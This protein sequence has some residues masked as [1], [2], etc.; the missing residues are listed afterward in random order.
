MRCVE[1]IE[2]KRLRIEVDRL[3]SKIAKLEIATEKVI[4]IEKQVVVPPDDYLALKRRQDYLEKEHK[5]FFCILGKEKP[6]EIRKLADDFQLNTKRQLE[7]I[8]KEYML[9]SSNFVENQILLEL[10]EFIE[11]VLEELYRISESRN[12][13]IK[14]GG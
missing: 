7:E 9:T 3:K 12:I 13:V 6:P 1:S 5:K 4:R 8:T 14:D 10:I 11:H 2:E